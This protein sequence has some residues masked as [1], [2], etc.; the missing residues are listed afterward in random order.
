MRY[1]LGKRPA[2]HAVSFRFGDF[3]DK[4]KLPTPPQTFG[5]Y[6]NV[7]DWQMLGNDTWGNCVWAGAAH[8]TQMWSVVGGAPRPRFTTLDTLRD[9]GA[10]T[11]FDPKKPDTDQGT[12]MQQAASYRRKTG[13]IDANGK[14]HTIDSYVALRIGNVDE[15]V[16]AI[17]LMGAAG[18]GIRMP[19]SA[20]TQFD[21]RQRWTIDEKSDIA[22]G[23]YVSGVGR[24]TRGDIVVVTWGRLHAMDPAF[25]KRYSDEALAYVSLEMLKNKLSPEGF[26]AD[27]LRRHLANLAA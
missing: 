18:I 9:Y 8:E 10:V 15:L 26:D 14:R 2:R 1:K 6:N 23:H 13:V 11:G 21:R 17:Y 24:N 22:G 4:T 7:R 20:M 27:A 16:L 19:E 12:D 5:H 25:Y 3:F